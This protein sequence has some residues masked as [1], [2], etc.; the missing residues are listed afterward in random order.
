MPCS[1]ERLPSLLS[2][3]LFLKP[4]LHCSPERTLKMY[5][6]DINLQVSSHYECITAL[7]RMK[8]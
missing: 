4:A 3:A 7:T 8:P 2:P 5:D 6:Y 1:P